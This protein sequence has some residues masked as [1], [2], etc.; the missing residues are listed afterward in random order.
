MQRFWSL[1]PEKCT[2]DI[3]Y[4]SEPWVVVLISEAQ[5]KTMYASYLSKSSQD[6]QL[7]QLALKLILGL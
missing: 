2:T 4:S 3:R 6:V 5:Y 1:W 7:F